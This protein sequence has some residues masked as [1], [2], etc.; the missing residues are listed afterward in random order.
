MYCS[1]YS[2]CFYLVYLVLGPEALL[3]K[4]VLVKEEDPHIISDAIPLTHQVCVCE[5][6]RKM[7]RRYIRKMCVCVRERER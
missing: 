7:Q 4:N 2:S 3:Y 1:K 6:E 5:Q